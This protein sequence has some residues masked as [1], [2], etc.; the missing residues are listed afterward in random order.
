VGAWVV[1][2]LATGF[3]A[4]TVIV[5]IWPGFGVGWFGSAGSA[6]DSLPESFAGERAQYTLSQV[7]PLLLFVG[8][9]LVFYAMGARTRRRVGE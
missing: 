6:A 3:V 7:L 1:S 8:I 9:G 2:V 5:L 4:F